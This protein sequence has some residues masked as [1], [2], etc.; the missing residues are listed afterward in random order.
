MPRRT[1]LDILAAIALGGAVGTLARYAI[2]QNLH[3]P[4]NGFPLATFLTN[5][6]GS[7]VLA[8]FVTTLAEHPRPHRYARPL[9][10]VGF[11]GAFTTFSTMAMETV[12]LVKHR[13]ALLGVTY[14]GASIATGIVLA[15]LGI[16]FTRRI[17][18]S[19]P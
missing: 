3:S 10:A 19:R 16:I 1:S 6:S 14:L 13:H 7:L 15:A 2:A 8:V 17:I 4:A 5:I 9:V 18:E 11:C 12:L